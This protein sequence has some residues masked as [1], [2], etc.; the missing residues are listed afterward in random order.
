MQIYLPS[1]WAVIQEAAWAIVAEVT[2]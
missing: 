2:R 1:V